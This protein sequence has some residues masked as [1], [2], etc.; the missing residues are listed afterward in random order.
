MNGLEGIW[1]VSIGVKEKPSAWEGLS[2]ILFL[3]LLFKIY[4][5]KNQSAMNL[6]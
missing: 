6:S 4:Q 5:F 2:L 1:V 3:T